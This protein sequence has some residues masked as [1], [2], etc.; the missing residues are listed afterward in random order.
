MEGKG[1]RWGRE[2]D[3]QR[4]GINAREWKGG[5]MKGVLEKGLWENLLTLD[6]NNLI[7]Y[8]VPKYSSFA[9]C[10]LAKEKLF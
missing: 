1:K 3:R 5:G 4:E 10:N 9:F 7:S 8:A 6:S 2:K